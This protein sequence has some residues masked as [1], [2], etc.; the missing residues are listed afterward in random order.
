MTQ[1]ELG[2]WAEFYSLEPFG[3]VRA[4]LRNALLCEVIAKCNG[5]KNVKLS[6]FL[7]F[8]EEKDDLDSRMIKA[9]LRV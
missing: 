3:E 6:D 7:L 1:K 4:D 2:E 9:M 5:A 8:K